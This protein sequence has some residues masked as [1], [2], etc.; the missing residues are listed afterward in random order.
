MITMFWEQARIS[1]VLDTKSAYKG[2]RD[3]LKGASGR[4]HPLYEGMP[5]YTCHYVPKFSK[6]ANLENL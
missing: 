5:K 1:C 4:I 3:V 2:N 6:Q